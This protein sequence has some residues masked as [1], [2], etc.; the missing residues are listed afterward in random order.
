MAEKT[1]IQKLDWIL[2]AI[3]DN[4]ANEEIKNKYTGNINELTEILEKLER[5]KFIK[6]VKIN[7]TGEYENTPTV[8]GRLFIGYEKTRLL[9]DERLTS[10][11]QM[12]I[13]TKK[14][15]T[16][17]LL[18]TLLAGIAAFLLLLWQV[19]LWINPTYSNFPY[20]IFGIIRKHA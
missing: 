8:E 18:A 14:Y 5:D 20:V 2:Q 12:A 15:N 9:E 7:S 19:F 4:V 13:A 3:N 16:R 6:R 17:L 10:I 11:G 1:L